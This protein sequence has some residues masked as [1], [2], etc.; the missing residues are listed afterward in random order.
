MRK[1]RLEYLWRPSYYTGYY[2]WYSFNGD[3]IYLRLEEINSNFHWIFWT[4]KKL[5]KREKKIVLDAM[6]ERYEGIE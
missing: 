4:F 3:N 2:G 6:I 1:E 5:T